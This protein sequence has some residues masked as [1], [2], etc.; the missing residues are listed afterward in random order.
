M[1]RKVE[2]HKEK[3]TPKLGNFSWHLTQWPF[4]QPSNFFNRRNY[5]AGRSHNL[6]KSLLFIS[7]LSK[8]PLLRFQFV[9]ATHVESVEKIKNNCKSK[10]RN[11]TNTSK[12]NCKKNTFTKYFCKNKSTSIWIWRS[13][14]VLR[15]TKWHNQRISF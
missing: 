2:G 7:L 12:I 15:L 5:L 14:N 6:D 13:V 9:N 10:N 8:Q 11:K 4:I 3:N 1:W